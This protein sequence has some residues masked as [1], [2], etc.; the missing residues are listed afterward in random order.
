MIMFLAISEL[1]FNFSHSLS[2]YVFSTTKEKNENREFVEKLLKEMDDKNNSNFYRF[3]K[4]FHQ[5]YIDSLYFEYNGLSSFISTIKQTQ[6]NFY[7]ATGYSSITNSIMYKHP[8]YLID[9]LNGF[10]YIALR[11]KDAALY[12]LISEH[13]YSI[14]DGFMY[15]YLVEK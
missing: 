10:K 3:D 1:F 2:S 13:K 4:N 7:K 6:L 12:N 11:N 15:E 5:T 9:S 8:N 14:F